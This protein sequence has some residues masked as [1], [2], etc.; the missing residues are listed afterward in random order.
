MERN[1][2]D[3]HKLTDGLLVATID[4]ENL[5]ASYFL[6]AFCALRANDSLTSLG[7]ATDYPCRGR[8]II[9]WAQEKTEAHIG[10]YRCVKGRVER[11]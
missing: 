5:S 11:C 2:S 9:R 6:H 10:P 7:N 1:Y 3:D 4:P 8:G